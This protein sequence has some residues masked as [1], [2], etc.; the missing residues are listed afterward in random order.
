MGRGSQA[1]VDVL[2][3]SVAAHC[4]SEVQPA[5]TSEQV[6]VPP[7]TLTHCP[8]T[9]LIKTHWSVPQSAELV[10]LRPQ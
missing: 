10:Q 4:A 9:P 6:Y 1:P 2:Q 8:P 3:R 5:G 7:R